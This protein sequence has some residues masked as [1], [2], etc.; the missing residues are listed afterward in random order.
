MTITTR[1][2][3]EE[4]ARELFDHNNRDT[5]LRLVKSADINVLSGAIPVKLENDGVVIDQKG[6]EK[7]LSVDSVVYAG[8]LTSQKELYESLQDTANVFR[9]GDCVEPGRIMDAVWGG[10]NTVR[11]IEKT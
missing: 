3:A 4:L 8:R 1:R 11:E 9:V 10:F 7:K 6:S 5:L 2:D